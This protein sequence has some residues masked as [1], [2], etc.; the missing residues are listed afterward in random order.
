MSTLNI[1]VVDDEE[2]MRESMA[3]WLEKSGHEVALAENGPKALEFLEQGE[4]DLVLLDIK[5]PG[6]DGHEL[7]RRIKEHHA[8]VMVVMIT[9]Y[10]SIESAV[11]AMKEG[12]N[13]Y[14][15]KPFDPKHLMLLIEKMANQK[16]TMAE[17]RLIR[18]R[19]SELE[20]AG[21]GD[22]IGGSEAMRSVFIR[23][24]E[25]AQADIPV[26]ITGETGTGK[27][28]V[29]RAIHARSARNC[30][31]FVAINCGAVP[32]QLLESELF[33][34]ERGAFTGAVRTRLGRLEMADQGSLF[35]DEVG[36]IS[37]QMQVNLLRALE[38]KS[39]LRVGGSKEVES[40]FR[41]ICA[42]H[43]DMQALVESGRVRTD[44]FYRINVISIH[45]PPLRE[46]SGDV[47]LLARHFVQ[48]FSN[49]ISK[50]IQDLTPNAYRL[51]ARH[52]WPGN[53]RELLN[54]IERAVVVSRGPM[55]DSTDL[56]FLGP[57]PE[58]SAKGATLEDVEAMHIHRTLDECDWNISRAAAILGI[59]RG[60][61]T[62][63]I[64]K[65]GLKKSC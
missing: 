56:T 6:M 47:A 49:E 40:D 12:A 59:N 10:G 36:E 50:P 53:V 21:F 19:L 27:E 14:L 25:V 3:A 13:D 29:A 2:A 57:E 62:R 11:S 30:G 9:A 5:M 38:E 39:F 45:V 64:K 43:R 31:P 60:T 16:G 63:H 20:G 41:L 8:D 24:E 34:H 54:V 7:L 28:L 61:L 4:Y 46:R 48:Q 32:Q 65:H 22:L 37:A 52:T 33:G 17:Y 15:M 23:I 42:T 1:L 55:I 26:L 18:A 35:L 44:F 51:L 58:T